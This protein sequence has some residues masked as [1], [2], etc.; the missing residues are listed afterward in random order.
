MPVILRHPRDLPTTL[1]GVRWLGLDVSPDS[2]G[3]H[4]RVPNGARLLERCFEDSLDEL[5]AL[6]R[7][8]NEDA[9]APWAQA[10]VCTPN[11][12]DLALMLARTRIVDTLATSEN[13]T[14]VVCD[15][16][17]LFRHLSG[18]QDVRAGRKPS[19]VWPTL[20]ALTRGVA[21]RLRRV[22]MLGALSWRYRRHRHL[23]PAGAEAIVVYGHPASDASG[24]DAYFGAFMRERPNM[25]RLLHTDAGA[26]VIDRL[27]ADRRTFALHAWGTPW[28][29]L[30][31]VF[32]FWQPSHIHRA[33]PH[34]WLIRR[35]AILE[36]ATAQAVMS[37]WQ[38][39][40]QERW[41]Q[42]TRP[43]IAAWP[44][45]NHAWE[46]RLVGV[47]HQVGT[48]TLGYQHSVVG[49]HAANHALAANRDG[50]DE[51]PD[52]IFC[53]SVAG[54]D[55]LQRWN[56]PSRRLE[57]AGALRDFVTASVTF[58]KN[59]PYF[60]ALPYMEPIAWEMID[61]LRRNDDPALRFLV[62]VHPMNEL[63]FE[64]TPTIA[65][66]EKGLKDHDRL[67]GVI[68]AAT[69]VGLEA[70]LAGL[71]AFR[72]IPSSCIAID[73]LSP[74]ARAID[75]DAGT[76]GE[77]LRNPLQPDALKTESFFAH[78]AMAAWHEM[79]DGDGTE[80]THD[81]FIEETPSAR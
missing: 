34:G 55:Q 72:F 51:I 10:P 68:F 70:L 79:F 60:V 33:G 21:A 37:R 30:R 35:A 16:P 36:G 19:R 9:T 15:D 12:S 56:F 23:C 26:E 80:V 2:L 49:R 61:A 45:E 17:W 64:D 6:G 74:P 41:I 50:L 54:R 69:T 43:D 75:V 22:L 27:A 31:M 66:T 1:N 4:S 78:P 14:L 65:R 76:L 39:F 44:W 57:I 48:R 58:D 47:A 25:V 63:G 40:C 11:A 73:I 67:S 5:W 8:L 77:A 3:E 53:N 18:R 32:S 81:D 71:P 62:K 52:R 13:E 38:I 29:A 59:A 28:A 46:R 7:M 20:R 24:R 42:S